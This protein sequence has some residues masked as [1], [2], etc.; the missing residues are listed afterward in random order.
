MTGHDPMTRQAKLL[1]LTENMIRARL[2]QNGWKEIDEPYPPDFLKKDPKEAAVL[3]PLLEKEDG[4]HLLFIRR[5][6]V[7]GDMHSGQVAFPG[8]GREA[9]DDS[10]VK[11]ALRE[12]REE[13]GISLERVRILGKIGYLKTISNFVVTPVVAVVPYPCQFSPSPEEVSRIFT[14]P[15]YWL[16]DPANREEQLRQLP[17]PYKPFKVIYF[18]PYDGEVLWGASARITLRFL[19][20][21]KLD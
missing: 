17:G 15:L 6:H 8:G 10:L 1:D 2:E 21:L 20:I 11:T 16:A 9:G 7:E 13:I 4:W 14:I 12:T 19:E 5:T 3:L 18:K